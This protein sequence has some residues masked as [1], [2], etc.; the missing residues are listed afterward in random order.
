MKTYY[1]RYN[2]FGQ[3]H[4][5]VDVL[6]RNK[7]EAYYKATYEVIPEIEGT[8]AYSTWVES[9]TYNNGGYKL[10]N[11]FEGKPY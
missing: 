9:V 2:L 6:A 3:K 4:P 1:V 5:G 7:E 10:F 11:T 8:L